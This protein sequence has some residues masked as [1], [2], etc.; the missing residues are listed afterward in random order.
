MAETQGHKYPYEQAEAFSRLLA[1]AQ[2]PV[3]GLGR[4][5]SRLR[6]AN[7]GWNEG[8]GKGT[9]ERVTLTYLSGARKH[10][11]RV[12]HLRQSQGVNDV[13]IQYEA[14]VT[15]RG[16]VYAYGPKQ[17]K[18]EYHYRGNIYRDWNLD[19]LAGTARR[20]ARVHIN[21]APSVVELHVW[22]EPL[23]LVLARFALRDLGFFVASLY[24]SHVQ[25]LAVLKSLKPLQD[26][27]G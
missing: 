21:G 15:I 4:K 2:F 22:D 18:D 11:E 9:V 8:H 12:L 19:E 24:M 6:L 26:T 14:Q 27:V 1:E 3:Y 7:F 16:L 5:Q 23:Q 20:K 10:P 17:L 25:L 13:P